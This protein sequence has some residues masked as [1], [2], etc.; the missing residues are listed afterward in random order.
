MTENL[1]L[2]E[3]RTPDPLAAPPLRWGILAPG[4]IAGS[5]VRAAHGFTRQRIVAVAS[6]NAERAAS[7]A[8]A[9]GIPTTHRDAAA[10]LDD[11]SIDA[12]Y[13]CPPHPFHHALARQA[14]DAGKHVLV[15]KPLT[16]NAAQGG[17]LLAAARDRGV[18]AMEAMKTRFLP[19]IDVLRQLLE[20]GVLGDLELVL[21][22]HGRSLAH[23]ARLVDPALGGGALLDLGCYAVSFAVA[24]LGV[25]DRLQAV[26]TLTDTRVDRQTGL[27]LSGFP[28]HPHAIARLSTT[29]AAETPSGA[30]ICG[31]AAGVELDGPFYGPGGLRLVTADRRVVEMPTHGL[32]GHDAMAYEIAHLASLVAEGRTDSPLMPLRESVAVMALMDEARRQVGVRYP[33][34]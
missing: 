17:D 28:A 30:A 8:A 27:T 16:L 32:G 13:V 22:D 2:P 5:F 19:R 24:V 1:L 7:F 21:A 31:T 34:E 29:L 18:V 33:G 9:H 10:L 12:V 20:D 11:P 3:P 6:R 23:V 26:G 14:I 4:G 25:P 15:E